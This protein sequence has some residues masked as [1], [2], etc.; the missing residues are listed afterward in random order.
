M[1]NLLK[2]CIG[3]L[4]WRFVAGGVA[5]LHRTCR[6]VICQRLSAHADS[7]FPACPIPSLALPW[8]CFLPWAKC[9]QGETPPSA[10]NEHKAFDTAGV[11]QYASQDETRADA[12]VLRGFILRCALI[13]CND[14]FF[15]DILTL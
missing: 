8:R 6:A 5:V 13:E 10:E 14:K 4:D 11:G 15:M 3:W 7:A 2:Q 1:R 12:P 9:G